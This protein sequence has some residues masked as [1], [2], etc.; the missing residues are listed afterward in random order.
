MHVDG[1]V[2]NALHPRENS[3]NIKRA[4]VSDITV[5]ATAPAVAAATTVWKRSCISFVTRATH[6]IPLPSAAHM[7]NTMYEHSGI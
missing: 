1:M 6:I 4:T 7:H 5:A 3:S 2:P